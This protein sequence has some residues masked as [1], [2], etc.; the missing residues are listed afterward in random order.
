VPDP[1]KAEVDA[2]RALAVAVSRY[3]EH[4]QNVA[5]SARASA[6]A[7]DAL[8]QAALEERR[9]HMDRAVAALRRAE[10]ALNRS[11][12]NCGGLAHAVNRAQKEFE[13]AEH[14]Y[15]Q[16]QRAAGIMATATAK[17]LRS[18]HAAEAIVG[19]QASVSSAALAELAALLAE[20]AGSGHASW[21]QNAIVGL[22]FAATSVTGT[23][24]IAK[25]LD[26]S[27]IQLRNDATI[28]QRRDEC[29]TI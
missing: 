7:A 1:V 24:Y 19:Q 22:G 14:E 3:A 20:I 12:K 4:L 10:D 8:I 27:T 17:L 9:Q 15:H 11:A 26:P 2:V 13:H 18:I 6:R 23:S 5:A 25:S 28:A 16:A 21:W 29:V